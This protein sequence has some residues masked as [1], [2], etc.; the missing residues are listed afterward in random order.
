MIKEEEK[1]TATGAK[2]PREMKTSTPIWE[3]RDKK[4]DFIKQTPV[5]SSPIYDMSGSIDTLGSLFN[6]I[7]CRL[8]QPT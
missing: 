1:H 8:N 4:E 5:K 2:K 3:Y 7:G 6:S